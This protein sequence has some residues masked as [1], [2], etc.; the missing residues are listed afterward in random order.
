M[1]IHTQAVSFGESLYWGRLYIEPENTDGTYTDNQINHMVDLYTSM[2]W[3]PDGDKPGSLHCSITPE[4][5]TGL[6]SSI[7]S[8]EEPT[9]RSVFETIANI[10]LQLEGRGPVAIEK[11]P[12][13]VNWINRIHKSFPEARYVAMTRDAYGFMRSYKHQGDRLRTEVRDTFQRLYHPVGCAIVWRGFIRSILRAEHQHSAA[14][15]RIDFRRMK[16]DEANVLKEVQR[17]FGLEVE[18]IWGKVAAD[19]TSFPEGIRPELTGADI[20]WMNL[21]AG[22]AMRIA[23]YDKTQ[24]GWPLGEILMSIVRLPIWGVAVIKHMGKV[25][26]GSP[27]RYLTRWLK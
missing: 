8:I 6:R 12:H 18:E 27:I 9:P 14:V 16:E 26:G 11:T 22:R 25:T 10:F 7:Q 24:S 21:I 3:G 1:N 2:R 19:N 17:H 20:F 23:G 13:H 4:L 15:L 5:I